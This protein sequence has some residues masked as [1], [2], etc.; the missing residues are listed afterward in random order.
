MHSIQET[1]VNVDTLSDEELVE[2]VLISW[3][4]VCDENESQK[5]LVTASQ[6]GQWE[7]YRDST[8]GR[9]KTAVEGYEDGRLAESGRGT[10]IAVAKDIVRAGHKT[11]AELIV[12]AR[13]AIDAANTLA[14]A[15]TVAHQEIA[16]S[17]LVA[18][19]RKWTASLKK[20]F[21]G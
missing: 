15:P 19:K 11:E 8:L 14:I 20:M 13:E 2:T 16:A 9:M 1:L 3:K 7:G 6:W 18:Y 5:H 4:V 17:P 21:R 10:F 12:Q